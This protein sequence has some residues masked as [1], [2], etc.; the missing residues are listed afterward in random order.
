MKCQEL[1]RSRN[2]TVEAY[3]IP[4]LGHLG[5]DR[6]LRESKLC[7]HSVSISERSSDLKS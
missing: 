2:T 5:T 4:L 6:R 3:S 1:K 7:V